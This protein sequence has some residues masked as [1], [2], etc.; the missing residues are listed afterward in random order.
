MRILHVSSEVAPFSKTGGLADVA[1]ALPAAQRA[2]GH[3][4]EVLTPRYRGLPAEAPGHRF[5][6]HPVFD[7]AALY[8]HPD[9]PQR[10]AWLCRQAAALASQFD[11]VHLHDWHAALAAVYI[12][13]RVPV[14]YTIHNLAYRGEC[15]MEL[16]D[17]LGVPPALRGF[18]GLEFHGHLALGK[19]GIQ[20]ADRVTTV[21]PTYAKEILEE[22]AGQGLAAALRWRGDAFSG[23]LN[24]LDPNAWPLPDQPPRRDGTHFAVISRAAH[25]KGLDLVIEAVDEL[26]A[27]GGRLSIISSGDPALEAGLRACAQRYPGHVDAFIGFSEAKARA[28]YAQADFVI[29][30]SRFE[31][32]GLTQLI[33]MRYG[34][35]PI[36]R[37]TGGLA[38]TVRDG[39]TGLVFDDPTPL[40]LRAAIRRARALP[41]PERVAMRA[42]C[43]AQDWSWRPAAEAYITLYQSI[44]E[45]RR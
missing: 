39:I 17:A 20:R 9:D 23:I 32:C 11:V 12:A 1:A 29:I 6:A 36:V 42:R 13:G 24:G 2:L 43:A 21:S 15:A 18:D 19:A 41:A 25:Q 5:V 10:F 33:A 40:A 35:I 14:V 28:L 34:A 4:A 7:R 44:L 38:D 26:V 3:T 22:P 45:E 30:P 27:L 16:A 37:R 8:G 31:P